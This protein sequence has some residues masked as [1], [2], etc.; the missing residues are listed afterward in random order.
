MNINP[1]IERLERE[2]MLAEH[3]PELMQQFLERAQAED[4]RA[5]AYP[6]S[7]KTTRVQLAESVAEADLASQFVN[8]ALKE[9]TDRKV[10]LLARAG[11]SATVI[12]ALK[13]WV[14]VTVDARVLQQQL[15]MGTERAPV[16]APAADPLEPLTA[17]ELGDAL[18]DLSEDTVRNRERQGKLF[19]VTRPGRKRGR[20]YPAFQAW[21]EIAGDPLEQV[22]SPL[23]GQEGPAL[24]GFFSSPNDLLA[25]LTPIEVLA[26]KRTTSRA[27][28]K[29]AEALLAASPDERRAAAA[30]AAQTYAG[31]LGA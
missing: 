11:F 26:G 28:D 16:I 31:E 6:K 5:G 4:R 23:T 25:N 18:G 8:E 2:G 14:D 21:P 30:T 27:L 13:A 19:S 7:R 12:E 24:Y 22:L 15:R 20:E 17:R 1:L 29:G 3:N 10:A 9:V